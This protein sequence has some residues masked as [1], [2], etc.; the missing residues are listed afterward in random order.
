MLLIRFGKIAF[1]QV[2]IKGLPVTGQCEG[3]FGKHPLDVSCGCKKV[4]YCSRK[5]AAEDK[6]YHQRICHLAYDSD[7]DE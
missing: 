5:C 7:D 3:C 6:S 1:K 4:L 2:S